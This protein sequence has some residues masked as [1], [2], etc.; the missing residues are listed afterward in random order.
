[1]TACW[2]RSTSGAK[3]AAFG[4]GASHEIGKLRLFCSYHCSR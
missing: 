1:M 2:R 4:H 3:A